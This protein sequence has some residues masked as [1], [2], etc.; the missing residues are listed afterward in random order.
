MRWLAL[1]ALLASPAAA[2]DRM[3][4]AD[5]DNAWLAVLDVVTTSVAAFGA[6]MPPDERNVLREVRSELTEDGWCRLRK[7]VPGLENAEFE[8][9]DWQAEDIGR[10]IQ[11]G[12]PPLALRMRLAGVENPGADRPPVDLNASLRQ[13]PGTG[14]LLVEHL[15]LADADGQVLT[16]SALLSGAFLETKAS[17][18][19]SLGGIALRQG[20]VTL[21]LT[22]DRI[23]ALGAESGDDLGNF[24]TVVAAITNGADDQQLAA[25]DRAALAAL[26]QALPGA[27]GTLQVGLRSSRGFSWLQMALAMS[28]AETLDPAEVANFAL[29][30]LT[31]TADWQPK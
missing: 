4:L 14:Q 28:R 16:L 21:Y 13:L 19:S 8:T 20:E 6:P 22:P 2:Y 18:A 27:T 5:C 25:P 15:A 26:A 17:A 30:G 24:T 11:D 23:A 10:F 9:F 1:T 29:S 12:D 7:G 31:L 3:Q